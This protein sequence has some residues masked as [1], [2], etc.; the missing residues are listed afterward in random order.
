MSHPRSHI[1]APGLALLAA[2]VLAGCSAKDHDPTADWSKERLYEEAKREMD[3][4]SF[5]TAIDY[6]ETLEARFPFGPLA[7]QAQLDIAYAYYRY[8]EDESAIAACDRF[9]KLHPTH[10]AVAYAHYL[11]GLVRYNQ[12]RSFVNDVFP[13]DMASMDQDRLR[14]A[15]DD[16]RTVV[17]QYPD[18]EYASDA[19]KRLVYLRNEMAR[20]ELEVARF[21]VRRSAYPAAINRVDY[22][23]EH[24]DGAPAVPEALALQARAYEELGMPDMARDARRVLATNWPEHPAA[25]PESD[26]RRAAVDER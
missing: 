21:Y 23:V 10:E 4:A 12:G 11:R 19:R 2:V 15:F 24:F 17:E 25:G 18:S 26:R 9:I 3:G 14:T 5:Q 8:G 13:R 1:R 22:L 7:L 16:F 20:H 6:F